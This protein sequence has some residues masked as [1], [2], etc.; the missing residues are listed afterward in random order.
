MSAISPSDPRR[1]AL[2]LA[3]FL[4][5]L[6]LAVSFTMTGDRMTWLLETLPVMIALPLLWATHKRYPLTSLLY[7]LIF[8][9]CV[10]LIYGGIYTYAKTPFGFVLQDWLGTMRNPYDKIGHFVQGFVPAMM[11]REILLRGD[12]VKGPWLRSFLIICVVMFISSFYELLEWWVALLSGESAEAFL[13]TQGDPWDTQSDMGFAL[14]GSICALLLLSRWHDRQLR[15][16][17]AGGS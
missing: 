3:S 7:G 10:V 12:H 16:L 9:H 13:G 8:L 5:L 14:L 6:I 1:P 11:A 17:P 15:R 4:L 2:L